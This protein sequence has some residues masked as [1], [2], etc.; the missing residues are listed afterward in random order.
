MK[1]INVPVYIMFAAHDWA[2]SREVSDLYYWLLL[3]LN[4]LNIDI[5]LKT[6]KYAP[7]DREN[8]MCFPEIN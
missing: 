5:A 7:R 4:L 3:E 2:I 6:L 8:Y 1:K